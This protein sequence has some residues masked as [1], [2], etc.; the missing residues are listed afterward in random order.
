MDKDQQAANANTVIREGLSGLFSSMAKLLSAFG[1]SAPAFED[2]QTQMAGGQRSSGDDATAK[3]DKKSDKITL[4]DGKEV[5][6]EVKHEETKGGRTRHFIKI[7]R[8]KVLLAASK[9]GRWKERTKARRDFTGYTPT[10]KDEELLVRLYDF[11][12]KGVSPRFM[13]LAA[14]LGKTRGQLLGRYRTV[15][16]AGYVAKSG[17]SY[18]L[19]QKGK[20]YLISRGASAASGRGS[21][22]GGGR[23]TKKK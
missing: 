3:K 1:V 20:D 4:A 11:N 16:G 7:G 9:N 10:P 19:T 12:S 6:A 21:K 5:E 23:G 22:R 17:D 13:E 14:A 8:K 18:A 2:I 15:S